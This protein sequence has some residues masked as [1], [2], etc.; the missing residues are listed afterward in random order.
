MHRGN[1][2]LGSI[3]KMKI[4]DLGHDPLIEVYHRHSWLKWGFD[5]LGFQVE[6]G[7][8]ASDGIW[9]PGF[10][11]LYELICFSKTEANFSPLILLCMLYKGLSF[12]Q[13]VSWV[14]AS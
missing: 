11:M 13:I 9:L 14:D 4:F 3:L 12:D 1:V 7:T 2:W 10:K 5:S 6:K 8:S